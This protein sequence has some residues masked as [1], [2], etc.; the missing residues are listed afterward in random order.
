MKNIRRTDLTVLVALVSLAAV[1][2]L[3]AVAPAFTAPTDATAHI[4]GEASGPLA[5]VALARDARRLE[6][7]G[8]HVDV[9]LRV[10]RGFLAAECPDGQSVFLSGRVLYLGKGAGAVFSYAP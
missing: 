8:C 5:V 7:A 3:F 2:Y 4:Y 9:A 10:T 6:A 1:A